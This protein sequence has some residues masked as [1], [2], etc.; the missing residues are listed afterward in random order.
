[1]KEYYSGYYSLSILAFKVRTFWIYT[2][3]RNVYW[4]IFKTIIFIKCES[5]VENI[6]KKNILYFLGALIKLILLSKFD[7]RIFKGVFI[8]GSIFFAHF[9]SYLKKARK[10]KNF[11]F[12]FRHEEG[13]FLVQDILRC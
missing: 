6:Y 11:C 10:G 9:T 4:T 8:S 7:T 13:K 5:G 3:I 2:D 12:F 1:M